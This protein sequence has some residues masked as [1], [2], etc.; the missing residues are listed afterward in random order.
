MEKFYCQCK[1][2]KL[3]VTPQRVAIYQALRQDR[4]HPTADAVYQNVKAECSNISLDTVNRTLIKFAEIGFIDTVAC[5]GQGKKYDPNNKLH[6][7]LKC[8]KCG[9]IIDF[10]NKKYDKLNVPE[11]IEE[12]F[13]VISKKVV[14]TGICKKCLSK[15]DKK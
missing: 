6:H 14:L 7:H 1:K 2:H 4:T 9:K 15:K 3:R 8:I 13:T 10:Y 12:G 5:S 11:N